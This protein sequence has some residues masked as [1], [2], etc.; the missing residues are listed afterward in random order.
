MG[1]YRSRRAEPQADDEIG[2]GRS[3]GIVLDERLD[4]E[5]RLVVGRAHRVGVARDGRGGGGGRER[6][7]RGGG[8]GRGPAPAAPPLIEPVA[9]A[10]ELALE[11][12]FG[13]AWA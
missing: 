1:G 4:Q 11:V 3:P 2:P 9:A 5:R 8:R 7:G 12:T 13:W 6:M 10:V